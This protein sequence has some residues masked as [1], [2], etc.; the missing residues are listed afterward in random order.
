MKLAKAK[1]KRSNTQALHRC[2]HQVAEAAFEGKN[3][4]IE[5]LKADEADC[6]VSETEGYKARNRPRSSAMIMALKQMAASF[7]AEDYAARRRAL[8]SIGPILNIQPCSDVAEN[9]INWAFAR[10]LT[11]TLAITMDGGWVHQN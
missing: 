3:A 1:K 7:A 8:C 9:R 4:H 10:L 5:D 2:R 6:R 11:P